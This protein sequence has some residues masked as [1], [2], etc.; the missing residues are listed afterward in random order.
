[1][2]D[3]FLKAC[4]RESVDRPPVWILRQAG[5]YLPEYRQVREKVS[6]EQLLRTPELCVRVTLQPLARFRMDAAILFSDILVPL[7]PMG[8]T[9]TFEPA[10]VVTP[11]VRSAADVQKLR[12][13]D[14]ESTVPYV[15]ET[16]QILKKQL[17]DQVPLIGF[18]G[19]PFTLAAYAVEGRGSKDFEHV[20][21]LLHG[22]PATA[23]ALLEKTTAILERYCE[24]QIF[25]GAQAIQIFD[26]WAGILSREDYAT[27]AAPYVR[28]VIDVVRADGIPCIYFALNG[29]HLLDE[30]AECGA[31]VL[32]VDWRLAID[33]VSARVGHRFVLQGNLDPCVLLTSPAVVGERVTRI[34]EQGTKA[35]AHIFNL[36]HGILPT[37][38]VENVQALMDAVRRFSRQ[39]IG[40]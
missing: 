17:R 11:P 9:V 33:D 21:A 7:E 13:P 37:T 24:A 4:R 38:P 22:E 2:N 28:R 14:P 19:A 10:P 30:I 25:A 26:S 39:S 8:L 12:V 16:I 34:L 1:M 15:F 29:A 18:C 31:D 6:F 27:F 40:S 32:G 3:L 20:R 23:H 5:R 35:P 36:G